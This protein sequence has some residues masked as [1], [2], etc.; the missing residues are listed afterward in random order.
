MAT[1]KLGFEVNDLEIVLSWGAGWYIEID[2][3]AGSSG[4]PPGSLMWL[5]WHII[6]GDDA[7][8][9]WDAVIT[10]GKAVFAEDDASVTALLASTAHIARLHYTDDSGRK[11][12]LGSATSYEVE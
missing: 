9:T 4:F 10:D 11:F 6:V 3:V 12:V 2:P 5:D 7:A 1:V 8:F